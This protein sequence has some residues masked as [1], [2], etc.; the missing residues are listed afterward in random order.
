MASKVKKSVISNISKQYELVVVLAGDTTAA[1]AKAVEASIGKIVNAAGGKIAKVEN[2]GKKD[3][4]YSI[5][6]QTTG[7]FFIY[8][9]ELED[10]SARHIHDKMRLEQDVI[11]YL[12]IRKDPP[13]R[14]GKEE[15]NGKKS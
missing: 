6:K 2:W 12:L 7:A 4:A 8:G 11:R 9:L 5:Q 13:Q 10:S 3:F 1:K 15:N 14:R